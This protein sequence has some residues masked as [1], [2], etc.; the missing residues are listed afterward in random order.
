MSAMSPNTALCAALAKAKY[1]NQR[2]P[3]VEGKLKTNTVFCS[4]DQRQLVQT[5]RKGKGGLLPQLWIWRR[6]SGRR[7]Q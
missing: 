4:K 6:G 1:V 2:C 5:I 7:D 3:L